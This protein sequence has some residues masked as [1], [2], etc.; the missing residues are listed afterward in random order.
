L[1]TIWIFFFDFFEIVSKASEFNTVHQQKKRWPTPF[2]SGPPGR[3]GGGM[4][5]LKYTISKTL[6]TSS[7]ESKKLKY[8]DIIQ[9]FTDSIK[10]R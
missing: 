4:K 6:A 1:S 10:S 3:K 2:E 5:R 8:I 7:E 9:I